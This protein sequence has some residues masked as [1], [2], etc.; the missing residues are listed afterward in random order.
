ME[1][2]RE[3]V[4]QLKA[5]DKYL[6]SFPFRPEI[7]AELAER[8]PGFPLIIVNQENEIL[9]GIDYYHYLKSQNVTE[10]DVMCSEV[11]DK[12]ALLLNFNL[13]EKLTGVNLYE[14]LVFVR[15][16]LPL[17]E[18]EEIYRKTNLDITINRQLQ[19]SLDLLLTD[20]F[21]PVLTGEKVTLKAALALCSFSQQDRCTLLEL[22]AAIPFTSSHQLKILEMSEEILFRDKQ[23]LQEIFQRL[24]I[25]K[26]LE[27]ERP[28]KA[29]IDTLFKHRNP[30]YAESEKQWLEE[31]EGMDLPG[32]MQVTHFP[33]FEKKQVRL[34]VLLD[35]VEELKKILKNI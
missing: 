10:T 21:K 9:F 4:E 25:E 1:L 11:N 13:K 28:Q 29:I 16:I 33:F 22:F 32:N 23:P 7:Y 6:L 18:K 15:K 24:D 35:D 17:A 14:K 26:S 3:K 8:L 5:V 20:E 31:I 2:K 19:D 12:E 34:T 27:Q 30:V